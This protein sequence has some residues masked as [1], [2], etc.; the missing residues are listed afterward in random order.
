MPEGVW[1]I[2]RAS[3]YIEDS[4]AN[5]ELVGSILARA[6]RHIERITAVRRRAASSSPCCTGRT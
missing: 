4:A 2:A 6:S 1:G 5:L 3:S